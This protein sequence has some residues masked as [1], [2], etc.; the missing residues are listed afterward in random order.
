RFHIPLIGSLISDTYSRDR[1]KLVSFREKVKLEFIRILNKTTA[2]RSDFYI[3]VA[4]AI[5]KPNQ[6]YLGISPEKI[7]VIPN[8]RDVQK[9]NEAVPIDRKYILNILKPSDKI[10]VSNSRVI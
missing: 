10:I 1:Y 5:V 8:G 3:S 2:S 7:K 9:Y 4:E 6:Q